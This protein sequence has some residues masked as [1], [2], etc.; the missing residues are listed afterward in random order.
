M[1]TSV[2]AHIEYE[3][4]RRII[5]ITRQHAKKGTLIDMNPPPHTLK[6]VH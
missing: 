5:Y 6:R 4:Q 1:C 2:N 3:V